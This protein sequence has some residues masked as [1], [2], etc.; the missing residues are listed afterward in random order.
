L[1]GALRSRIEGL[2]NSV[3]YTKKIAKVKNKL[4]IEKSP[5]LITTKSGLRKCLVPL[6]NII[7]HRIFIS[8]FCTIFGVVFTIVAGPTIHNWFYPS[9]P[10]NDTRPEG[11]FHVSGKKPV[12]PWIY[13]VKLKR[14][15][16]YNEGVDAINERKYEFA[17]SRFQYAILLDSLFAEARNNLGYLLWIYNDPNGGEREFRLAL[18]LKSNN[19]EAH[20]NLGVVLDGQSKFKE[21]E[22][23]FRV[24]IRLKPYDAKALENLAM[25]L[26]KQRRRIEG[27]QYWE[28]A[29]RVEKLPDWVE[30]IKSRLAT[31]D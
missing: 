10:G 9:Q 1:S 15:G 24:A 30:Q 16:A 26:D 20:N 28:R 8:I 5:S 27:R 3:Y 7:K 4:K 25:L 12:W 29:L 13:G 23:E 22:E 19:M 6:W 17:T 11:M 2:P 31:S 14:I 21:A 18:L